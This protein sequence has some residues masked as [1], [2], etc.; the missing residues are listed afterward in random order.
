MKKTRI[1]KFSLRKKIKRIKAQMLDRYENPSYG[2]M[3][4][5]RAE[6]IK[7]AKEVKKEK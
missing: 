2:K 5:E 4:E 3:I 7:E 1:Q 6:A